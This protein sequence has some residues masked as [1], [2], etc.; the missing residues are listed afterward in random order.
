MGRFLSEDPIG[1][2]SGDYNMY[3]YLENNPILN[4]DPS[5]Q[6]SNPI[7]INDTAN[8][9]ENSAGGEGW[10]NAFKHC[11]AS[12]MQAAENGE[13]FALLAGWLLEAAQT[14]LGNQ[15][16]YSL[17]MDTENNS[18]GRNLGGGIGGAVLLAMEVLVVLGGLFA[19]KIM[20]LV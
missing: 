17:Y 12:C 19:P 18:V 7:T 14:N 11:Y 6:F 3:R 9:N 4:T 16:S 13:S 20:N 1:F 15:S 10:K 8:G 5:G 2:I